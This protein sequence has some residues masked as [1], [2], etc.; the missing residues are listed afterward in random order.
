MDIQ[1][2]WLEYHPMLVRYL[3]R[4]T[5][6]RATAEDL[7]QTAFVKAME[8]WDT[9]GEMSTNH[10]KAWLMCTARNA[11]IDE[12]RKNKRQTAMPEDHQ[13]LYEED[14]TGIH[15]DEWMA[16]LPT[17]LREVIRLRHLEGYNSQQ[18][19]QALNLPPATVRTRLRAARILLQ[20]YEEKAKQ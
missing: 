18:I 13:P 20:Q 1:T 14:F 12:V 15:V 8:H 7:A 11:F 19:G 10:L 3:Q 9:V 2:I 6:E 5:R 4:F 16:H 17:N